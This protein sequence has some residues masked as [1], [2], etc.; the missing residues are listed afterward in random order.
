MTQTLAP[1]TT[2]QVRDAVAWAVESATPLTVQ[3]HG[4]K[5][6]LG[7]P[8]N[9]TATLD[10]SGL[11]GIVEYLPAEL[12][13]TARAGTP[14]AEIQAALAAQNQQM[15][16]EPPD[17]TALLGEP[18]GR[19]TVGGLV[20]SNLAGPRRIA[21][22]AV[23]DHFLGCH[24][25]GG[26]AEVFKAGGKVVKNVTGF[27]LCKLLAGSWGTLSVLTEVTLKVL[28][29]PEDTRTVVVRGLSDRDAV[30]CLSAALQSSHE[31][32]GAAHLPA[33]LA[34]HAVAGAGEAVTLVR[35]EGPGPS[36]D[37]RAKALCSELAGFGPTAELGRDDS[38]AAW[39]AVRD[40]RP[41][42]EPADRPV[43][44][45]SV[46]PMSGPAVVEALR[47]H[48][49]PTAFYDWGGGQV[50]LTLDGPAP[51]EAATLIRAAIAHC[52]GG[53]ATLVR[54][55][56]DVRA[57]VPVFQPQDGALAALSRR[58]KETYDPA[59]VLNPGRMAEGL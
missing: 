52:G 50:W 17:L 11:S 38:L 57:A 25:V 51:A 5:R 14:L 36:V 6:A 15:A 44:R 1:T 2:D 47:P 31:V 22:G 28:P 21:V 56:E 54:A 9:T 41:L 32:V 7:R 27:D 43:W 42:V 12:I 58:L 8:T 23:R 55:P 34:G 10:L 49:T 35:V 45:L 33:A 48:G 53:H 29:A 19:G 26:R 24:A 18:A 40:V 37:W 3:G 39:A 59:R 30:K 4:S 16:F 13:L 20:A 46:P